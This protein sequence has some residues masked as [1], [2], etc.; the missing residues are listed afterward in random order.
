LDRDGHG[1][2]F[3]YDQG[4]DPADALSLSM[5]VRTKSYNKDYGLLPVFDTNLPEGA[6]LERLTKSIAKAHGTADAIDILAIT[7]RNQIGRIKVL[8][9]GEEPVRRPSVKSIDE[10]LDHDA[11]AAYIEEVIEKYAVRSGVS[12]AMPKV[13][14]EEGQS[15]DDTLD[16]RVTVQTRDWIMKFDAEDYPGLSL[17]EYHCLE[18]ARR[19]GNETADCVLAPHG[20]SLAV[21][22]FDQK[23]DHRLG[24]EDFASLNAKTSA[25][26]YSGSIERDLM[27]RLSGIPGAEMQSNLEAAYRM[28]VTNVALRNGDAH[29]KNFALLFEDA[30]KGPFTLSPAYDMVTTKAYIE[31]DMMAM[32]LGGS[33]RW[34]KPK[35]L[36]ALGARARLSP[37]KAKEIIQEVADAVAEVM[38]VMLADFK[39][40]GMA[41]VGASIA[42]YWNEGLVDSLGLDPVEITVEDPF[43]DQDVKSDLSNDGGTEP[44]VS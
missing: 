44:G 31:N 15:P 12:G 16:H 41:E 32:T 19:A 20:K 24:F 34:P 40:R 17:N 37:A 3:V 26:K 29:L 38:P 27:K 23:D 5:P 9:E 25:E 43:Q 39:E 10:I 35:A 1:T 14:I 22:R 2:T 28:L 4:V 21:R 13:L 7:G 11:T 6:L 36:L 8:A 33:K 18:V 42:T 30:S